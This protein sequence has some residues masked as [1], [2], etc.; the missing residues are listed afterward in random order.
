VYLQQALCLELG[1]MAP[2]WVPFIL[3][4]EQRKKRK[5]PI[6]HPLLLALQMVAD[7]MFY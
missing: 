3:G 5:V 2:A 6:R 1:V 4:F 7:I